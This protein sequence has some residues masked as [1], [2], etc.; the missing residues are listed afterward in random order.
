MSD[1][2]T[3]PTPPPSACPWTEAT[4]GAGH[5]SIA[6]SMRLSA[7]ASATFASRSRS[8]DARIHSTSAPAQKL[9]P[10]PDSTTARAVPTSTNAS[11]SSAISA[12]SNAL[13]DAGRASVIRRTSPSRSIRSALTT[14]ELRVSPMSK[15]RR[16]AGAIAAAVTPLRERGDRLDDGAFGPYADFLVGAGLDGILAFGTNG[17]AVLLTVEERQRG[18][19]LWLDAVGGRAHVAAHCGAQ[20]TADTV[21]LAAHARDA[22]ADAV[23]VIG[24]PYF[25]LDPR[26]QRAHLIAAAE[27]CAPLPFYVYE[28]AATAGYAFDQSMLARLREDAENVTGMKVSD[29]PWDAFSR[30]LLDGYD[31]FVG[32]EA[33]IHRG[34][35]AGAIGAVSALASAFPEEVAAVVRDPTDEGAAGLAAL[36]ERMESFPR[37]AALKRVVGWKGV[38][39]RPDV[40]PPLRDLDTTEIAELEGWLAAEVGARVA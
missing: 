25:K 20:T 35:E 29:S 30:Y 38:P 6:S 19:E 3:R 24:P 10:S 34:R 16:L 39:L 14:G 32:P 7:V 40:R 12:A 2:E 37:H 22:D 13:R 28:F 4:T 5:P 18:L 15:G 36:R 11:E 8:A 33:L 31:I 23:A 9:G 17:E 21:A 26:E 1:T 27:A